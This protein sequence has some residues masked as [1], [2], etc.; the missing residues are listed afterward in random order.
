MQQI[1]VTKTYLPPLEEYTAYLQEIWDRRHLTNNGPLLQELEN[2]LKIFLGVKHCLVVNNGTIAIQIAIKALEL[3]GELITTPFSYVATTSSIAWEN[4]KPIFADIDRE[5]LCICPSE[6]KTRITA[7]TSGIVATHVYGNPC[8]VEQ[9]QSI[10]KDN[11][12]KVIYDAAHAFGVNYKGSSIL[13]YGNIST[14]S[15]H[16]TKLFHTIEGGAIITNNDELA[17][18][19]AYMRN[20]GH[21]GPEAFDGIGING[22]ISEVNAAM[23]LCVLPKV[24]EL[25]QIRKRLSQLYDRLLIGSGLERPLLTE[26]TDYNFSYYPILFKSEN[27]LLATVD[28]LNK[29]GIFPRRYFYPSLNKLNYTGKQQTPVSEDTSVKVL[30]LPL[31]HDLQETDIE[32]IAAIIVS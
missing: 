8:D 10:A 12:L 27:E 32:R 3:K 6:I 4:C 5:T 13:N 19:I 9:I 25:I 24:P 21:N 23:G 31:F 26:N 30:C 16:A 29:S 11:N 7:N 20:F 14:L 2:K 22:K 15:F 18:K 17:Y 28:K 1:N